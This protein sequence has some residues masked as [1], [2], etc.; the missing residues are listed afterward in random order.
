MNTFRRRQSVFW[1]WDIPFRLRMCALGLQFIFSI[2]HPASP[3]P[4]LCTSRPPVVGGHSQTS[5]IVRVLPYP[6]C[7]LHP[8]PP[9]PHHLPPRSPSTSL[10]CTAP[11][12][13]SPWF[14]SLILLQCA[15]LAAC[16]IIFW[17]NAMFVIS[18]LRL[19]HSFISASCLHV[20]PLV[21]MLKSY[22]F[23]SGMTPQVQ[24]YGWSSLRRQPV[25]S[26]DPWSF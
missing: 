23:I 16:R 21:N 3:Y 20:P 4:F 14:L 13:L 6:S 19:F 7:S 10:K 17:D 9:H 26:T 18:S 5:S 22:S 2:P 8:R 24:R 12:Q 15:R 1:R 11:L 25:P